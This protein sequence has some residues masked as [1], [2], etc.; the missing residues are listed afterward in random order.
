M[1][2]QE[3]SNQMTPMVLY[4][5]TSKSSLALLLLCS[6]LE[7]LFSPVIFIALLLFF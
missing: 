1:T 7:T 6:I 3:F 2:A 5:V 4:S